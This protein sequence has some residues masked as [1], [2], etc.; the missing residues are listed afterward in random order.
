MSVV[1]ATI[2]YAVCEG[3]VG[4]WPVTV[5]QIIDKEQQLNGDFRVVACFETSIPTLY[6]QCTPRECAASDPKA[7]GT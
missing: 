7:V 3:M 2:T 5:V 1:A 4:L 6:L